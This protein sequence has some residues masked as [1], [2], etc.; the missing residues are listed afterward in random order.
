M[1]NEQQINGALEQGKG[2]IKEAAGALAG[3]LK[4]KASG[5]AQQLRGRAESLYGDAMDRAT[6]L[7]HERPVA[8]IAAALGLGLL[9]GLLLARE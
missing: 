4:T 6:G 3:D 7:A 9:I 5:A 1:M 2:R 8:A